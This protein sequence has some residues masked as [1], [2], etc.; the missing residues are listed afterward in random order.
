MLA[1][2]TARARLRPQACRSALDLPPAPPPALQR[3][4]QRDAAAAA[5]RTYLHAAALRFW[6]QGEAVQVV[7]PPADG[8][9]FSSPGFLQLFDAWLPAILE[10]ERGSWFED[11]RLL[12]SELPPAPAWQ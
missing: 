7:C 2:C 11:N 6:C 4:A 8:A 3:Y 12:R 1:C 9:E 5:E 10:V